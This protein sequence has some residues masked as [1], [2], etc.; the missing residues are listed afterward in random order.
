MCC[1]D[2]AH[3]QFQYA[4]GLLFRLKA[5]CGLGRTQNV[6]MK[7]GRRSSSDRVGSH[8]RSHLC[9]RTRSCGTPRWEPS[10]HGLFRD[11][12]VDTRL[13]EPTSSKLCAMTVSKI[14]GLTLAGRCV[15]QFCFLVRG[16]SVCSWY[17]FPAD[18]V[19]K[20]ATIIP[21]HRGRAAADHSDEHELGSMRPSDGGLTLVRALAYLRQQ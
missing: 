10:F 14:P 12:T 5:W 17:P 4:L 11:A 7:N 20:R 19:A 1:V 3:R 2:T 18:G 13:H 9:R 15:A 6:P 8:V 21:F 16:P